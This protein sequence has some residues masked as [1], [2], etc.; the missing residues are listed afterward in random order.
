MEFT[1]TVVWEQNIATT[2]NIPNNTPIDYRVIRKDNTLYTIGLE[3]RWVG[4]N[5]VREFFFS[6]L[7]PQTGQILY[8]TQLNLPTAPGCF[9]DFNDFVYNPVNSH[10]YLSYLGCTPFAVSVIE[11]DTLAQ[12]IINQ[13]HLPYVH[14]PNVLSVFNK[15]SDLHI[16]PDGKVIVTYMKYK[17]PAEESR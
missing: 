9:I 3:Q 1:P 14:N 12:T 7:N 13:Q 16:T 6:H 4:S 17:N 10:F 5:V 2:S 8:Q 11:F 15:V